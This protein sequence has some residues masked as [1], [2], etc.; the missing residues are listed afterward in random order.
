[1][2][3]RHP[4]DISYRCLMDV[5]QMSCG[6]L[7]YSLLRKKYTWKPPLFSEVHRSPTPTSGHFNFVNWSWVSVTPRSVTLGLRENW[8]ISMCTSFKEECAYSIYLVYVWYLSDRCLVGVDRCLV[9]HLAGIWQLSIN[10]L[11]GSTRQISFGGNGR[12][13]VLGAGH[14]GAALYWTSNKYFSVHH[15]RWCHQF[16]LILSHLIRFIAIRH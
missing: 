7:V 3:T 2:Y 6:C 1:M 15:H 8:G 5:W 16:I 4:S 11:T 12:V 13:L 14:G 10:H 9:G